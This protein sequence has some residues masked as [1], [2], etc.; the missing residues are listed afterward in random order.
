MSQLG[1]DLGAA[2]EVYRAA[3]PGTWLGEVLP[4]EDAIVRLEQ[5]VA[6]GFDDIPQA[7]RAM[8]AEGV[9][10]LLSELRR[11]DAVFG[12]LCRDRSP[13][14]PLDAAEDAIA[15]FEEHCRAVMAQPGA[16]PRQCAK[17]R[18]ARHYS[19][20]ALHCDGFGSLVLTR[21]GETR[22]ELVFHMG[23]SLV[24]LDSYRDHLQ[25]HKVPMQI[26][27]PAY[28][29]DKIA[30]S[31]KGPAGVAT[32]NYGGRGYVN[33][34]MFHCGEYSEC[35][36]WSFVP[37]SQWQGETFTY[38]EQCRAWDSGAL[39]R[40][41]R[42]GLVVSV[43]GVKCVLDGALVFF[44]DTGSYS[45]ARAIAESASDEDDGEDYPDDDEEGDFDEEE[46]DPPRQGED[47]TRED[48]AGPR[49]DEEQNS[50]LFLC[51]M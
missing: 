38:E 19:T 45:L 26:W 28:S 13:A 22:H 32:F 7:V 27:A 39:E 5:V 8:Y 40:G 49:K 46:E 17:S 12:L 1:F 2:E 50:D 20:T 51:L 48:C 3:A 44:D 31:P 24:F 10:C 30:Y 4:L 36:G 41:D 42:R 34:G 29:A 6:Q 43:R 18:F 35:E 37:L 33:D 11:E 23:R 16:H 15:T 9:E 25:R 14:I 47:A 21:W